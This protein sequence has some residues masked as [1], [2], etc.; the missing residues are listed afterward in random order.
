MGELYFKKLK[1]SHFR[2]HKIS[3]FEFNP[4]PI[5]FFGENGVG[6]TNI[7]EAISLFSPGKGIRSAKKDEFVKLPDRLGWKLNT[8]FKKKKISMK[9][10]LFQ[11]KILLE[12]LRL[13]V[14]SHLN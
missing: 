9:Y 11:T 4:K 14:K 2:S 1:I 10:L 7:L 8:L 3:N 12:R 13:T 5:V 6:K